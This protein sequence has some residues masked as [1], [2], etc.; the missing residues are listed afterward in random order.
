MGVGDFFSRGLKRPACE[1]DH[2]FASVAEVK[3]AW[4]CTYNLLCAFLA[5]TE[6]RVRNVFLIAPLPGVGEKLLHANKHSAISPKRYKSQC[7]CHKLAKEM[8]G[9]SPY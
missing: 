6:T 5:C 3:N 8:N 4:S 9:G 7:L 2:L 1:A